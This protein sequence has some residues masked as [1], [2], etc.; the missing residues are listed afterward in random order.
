M[1]DI[2]FISENNA[3]HY[4][5]YRRSDI[6]LEI[7]FSFLISNDNVL[8]LSKTSIDL[9]MRLQ[10]SRPHFQISFIAANNTTKPLAIH[11]RTI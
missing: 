9:P 8:I 4:L 3:K 6:K 10:N 5:L 7:K 11:L 2:I 1:F